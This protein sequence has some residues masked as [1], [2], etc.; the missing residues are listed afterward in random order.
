MKKVV[1]VLLILSIVF[2]IIGGAFFGVGLFLNWDNITSSDHSSSGFEQKQYEYDTK[3][4]TAISFNDINSAVKIIATNSDKVRVSCYESEK[5]KYYINMNTDGTLII[6]RRD[7]R[8]WFEKIGIWSL[9]DIFSGNK[10]TVIEIPS[11]ITLDNIEILTVNGEVEVSDLKLKEGL[12]AITSNGEVVIENV[13]AEYEVSAV[14]TN[15]RISLDDIKA[16]EIEASTLNGRISFTSLEA[17][18]SLGF[19]TVNGEITGSIV[20]KQEDFK[21]STDTV[22]GKCNL[23]N[24]EYGIKKLSAGTV[25]GRIEIEFKE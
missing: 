3:G 23:K 5:E 14:T 4:L 13:N 9:S 15:G 2:V 6:E 8:S 25:N 24:K 10:N 21:I 18:E 17:S 16:K 22:I 11:N 20:G 7:D 19:D 1:K 12:T